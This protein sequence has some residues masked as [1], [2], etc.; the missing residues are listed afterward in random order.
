LNGGV[1][2]ILLLTK[3]S[4]LKILVIL[5]NLSVCNGWP[6]AH[7]DWRRRALNAF[8]LCFSLQ[9]SVYLPESLQ[10]SVKGVTAASATIDGDFGRM[11]GGGVPQAAPA[12]VPAGGGRAMPG[13]MLFA[14]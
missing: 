3:S 5:S 12:L 6:Q 10:T 14:Q 7:A 9:P 13:G 4:I 2:H 11:G 8:A 1:R